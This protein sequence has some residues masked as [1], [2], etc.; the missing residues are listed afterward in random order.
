MF[1]NMDRQQTTALTETNHQQGVMQQ[2][3][4]MQDPYALPMDPYIQQRPSTNWNKQ[5]L[6]KLFDPSISA[7]EISKGDYEVLVLSIFADLRRIPNL[8]PS[9]KRR[10][11]RDFADITALQQCGGTRAQVRSRLIKMLYEIHSHSS[12]GS[13][14]LTGITGVSAIITQRNQME[15]KVQIPQEPPRKKVFGIF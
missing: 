4:Y 13:S 8:N 3:P 11:N 10:L 6:D 5:M 1:E 12:D 7:K 2:D 9:D 15:Q 14:P